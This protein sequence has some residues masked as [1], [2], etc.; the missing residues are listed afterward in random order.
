[1]KN[2]ATILTKAEKA[3]DETTTASI[4]AITATSGNKHIR[5]VV[6]STTGIF[7]VYVKAEFYSDVVLLDA[8]NNKCRGFN[9]L[10]GTSSAKWSIT[11]ADSF[12]IT[13]VGDGWWRCTISTTNTTDVRIY[14]DD[15]LTL[16]GN[17]TGQEGSG[18]FIW[19]AQL[20]L[21]STATEYFAT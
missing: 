4:I 14:V 9:L 17:F 19:G 13:S 20:E 18:I 16:N 2:G 6:P 10:T 12:S 21:G 5:Q 15:G 11:S 3:P 8:T 1:V 7:S